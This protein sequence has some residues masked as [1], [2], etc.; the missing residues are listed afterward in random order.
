MCRVVYMYDP[1]IALQTKHMGRLCNCTEQA[2]RKFKS[3]AL[4]RDFWFEC[5][6]PVTTLSELMSEVEFH[7]NR[8]VFTDTLSPKIEEFLKDEVKEEEV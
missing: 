5:T 2:E 8:L 4:A 3:H 1:N 7:N 6:K